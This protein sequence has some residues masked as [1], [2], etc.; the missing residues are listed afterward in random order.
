MRIGVIGTGTIASAVVEGFA[1]DDHRI[2]VSERS[3]E[4]AAQLAKTY[5]S[6]S[7][8]ANQSVLDQSEVIFVGLM[9]EVA[10]D[11]LGNLTFRADHRVISLMAG[12]KIGDIPEMIAPAQVEAVMIPFPG[13]AQ[14]GSPIMVQGRAGIVR[15]LFGTKNQIFELTSDADLAAYMSAQAIL[16]PAVQMVSD[17]ATWLG[18]RV[19]D[20]RQAEVF[21]RM[22]VGS[23]L[24][25]GECAQL[26]AA[27][28]TPGGYNQR[29]RMHM[30]ASGMS[31]ALTEGLDKLEGN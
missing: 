5:E 23:S 20:Q 7:V 15:K 26:L 8:A 28:D 11:I 13:I 10:S 22:L 14:G 6:V 30:I 24:I 19:G 4:R 2:I 16:S 1:C 18:D 9:A 3:A 29:L 12:V 31:V 17:A 21:L 27:L 25:G